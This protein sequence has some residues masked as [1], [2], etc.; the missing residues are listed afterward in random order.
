MKKIVNEET[1]RVMGAKKLLIEGLNCQKEDS[2]LIY[3]D[4][5]LIPCAKYTLKASKELGIQNTTLIVNP[6][7]FRPREHAPNS[8]LKAIEG[9]DKMLYFFDRLPEETPPGTILPY[10]REI[11]KAVKENNLWTIGLYDCKP[12]YFDQGG[13]NADYQAV[14]DSACSTYASGVPQLTKV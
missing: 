5:N 4:E 11:S 2:L 6:N 12:W 14:E 3:S 9:T 10:R 7:M 8:L 13:I 1:F